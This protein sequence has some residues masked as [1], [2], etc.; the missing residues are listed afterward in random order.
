MVKIQFLWPWEVIGL[1]MYI[2][3]IT[4]LWM[5]I[6]R[7]MATLHD[8]SALDIAGETFNFETLKG[9]KVLIVNVASACGFTPQYGAL[10]EL[11]TNFGDQL[12]VIG[13]P[14]NQ[15]GGQEPGTEQEIASFCETKFGVTFKMMSK[16]DVKG[17]EQHPLFHWLTRKTKNEVEDIEI[18]WNFEKFMID[19]AGQLV[20]HASSAESPASEKMLAWLSA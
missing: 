4:Y 17:D 18:A 11:H 6:R 2:H 13:F 8:F 15:F 1:S 5:I 16:V 19:E 10:Q 7:I 20:W 14:C 12:A 3:R 9:K